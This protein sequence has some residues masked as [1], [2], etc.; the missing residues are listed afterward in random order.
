M[1]KFKTGTW[2]NLKEIES[3]EGKVIDVEATEIDFEARA[4]MVKS[5]NTKGTILKIK[6]DDDEIDKVVFPQEFSVPEM[7]SLLGCKVKYSMVYWSFREGSAGY[8]RSWDYKIEVLGGRDPGWIIEK[9][10]TV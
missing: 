7:G 2:D 9:K 1:E 8:L 3:T 6:T 4:L 5:K 10:I